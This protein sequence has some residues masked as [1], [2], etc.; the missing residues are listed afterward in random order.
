MHRYNGV[1]YFSYSTG[2]THKLCYATGSS[3]Y[4]PFTYRGVLLQPVKGWTTQDSII[5]FNGKWYLFYHDTQ[6]SGRNNLRNV[7]VTE[8]SYNADGTIRTIDPFKN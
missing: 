3:P 5:E 2:T 4:G 1:Y 8:L 7:K 6:L